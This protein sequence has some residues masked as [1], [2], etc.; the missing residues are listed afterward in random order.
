MGKRGGLII[1]SYFLGIFSFPLFFYRNYLEANRHNTF[2]VAMATLLLSQDIVFYYCNFFFSFFFFLVR[3]ILTTRKQR[4][5]WSLVFRTN[6]Q[7]M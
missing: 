6:G 1:L 2:G 5:Y 4:D 7:R 3:P